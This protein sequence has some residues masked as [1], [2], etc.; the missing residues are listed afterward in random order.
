LRFSD[1]PI[2]TRIYGAFGLV[3]ALGAIGACFVYWEVTSIAAELD[4]VLT[5]ARGDARAA[6]AGVHMQGMLSTTSWV[7]LLLAASGIVLGIA[8][9]AWL[10]S[11]V[12]TPIAAMTAIMKR[13][14]RGDEVSDIAGH[15]RKDEIGEMANAVEIFRRAMLD[16]RRLGTA[17]SDEHATKER[18]QRTI[19]E[20]S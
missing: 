1:V 19:D 20:H 13:L 3:V 15:G 2:R 17:Q 14:A 5:A 4:R 6:E 16:A 10:G 7:L 11:S 8:T 12:G 9:A 18:R